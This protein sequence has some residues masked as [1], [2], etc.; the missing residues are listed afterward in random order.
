MIFQS[1]S[2]NDMVEAWSV[3]HLRFRWGDSIGITPLVWTYWLRDYDVDESPNDKTSLLTLAEDTLAESWSTHAYMVRKS[4]FS[5]TDMHI[6]CH[7]C[8]YR[9]CEIWPWKICLNNSQIAL[10]IWR[11]YFLK[12]DLIQTQSC[13]MLLWCHSFDANAMT[14][15]MDSLPTW[16]NVR[17]FRTKDI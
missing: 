5:N 1:L 3:R 13:V 12:P 16:M 17:T 9:L 7:N 2:K 15:R 11:I 8:P 10:R 14:T 4:V 6:I